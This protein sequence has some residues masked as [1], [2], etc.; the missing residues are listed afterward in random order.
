MME[1]MPNLQSTQKEDKKTLGEKEDDEI[2]F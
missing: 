1:K 2:P